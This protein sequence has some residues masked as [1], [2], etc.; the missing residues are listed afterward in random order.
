MAQ[1]LTSS[2]EEILY[3]PR[4]NEETLKDLPV[5]YIS[6]SS[7]FDDGQRSKTETQ[8]RSCPRSMKHWMPSPMTI[9]KKLGSIGITT[10]AVMAS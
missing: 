6:T 1:A 2:I 8:G 10:M 7:F 9:S 3:E 5:E 4:D